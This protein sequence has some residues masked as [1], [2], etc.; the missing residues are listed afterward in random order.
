MNCSRL[1]QLGL[2][3]R[4]QDKEALQ[5]EVAEMVRTTGCRYRLD[6]KL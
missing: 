2:S 3:Y 5:V 6:V 1:S 4:G